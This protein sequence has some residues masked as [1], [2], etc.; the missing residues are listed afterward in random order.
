MLLRCKQEFQ[1]GALKFNKKTTDN[2]NNMN[3]F[4]YLYILQY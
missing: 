1:D 3:T 4:K 2:K